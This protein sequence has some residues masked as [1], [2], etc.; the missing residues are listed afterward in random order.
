MLAGAGAS[1]GLYDL[2]VRT[3]DGEILQRYGS[4]ETPENIST[5]IA[6]EL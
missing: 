5:D 3:I 1:M 4:V 2:S 6:A